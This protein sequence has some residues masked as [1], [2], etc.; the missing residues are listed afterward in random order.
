[1]ARICITSEGDLLDTLCQH[2]Y[3]QLEGMVEAVLDANQGLAD[4]A[5]PFRAGVRIVLPERPVVASNTLQL[6]D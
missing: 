2:Y 4:E 5:Q 1:M 3:G 6:W